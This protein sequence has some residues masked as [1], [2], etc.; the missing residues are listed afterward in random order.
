MKT[1]LCFFKRADERFDGEY[2]KKITDLFFDGGIDV[3]TLEVLSFNDISE[4]RKSFYKY[5]STANNLI[6]VGGEEADFD[7]KQIIAE[8]MN[9]TLTENENAYRFIQAVANNTGEY[10]DIENAKLPI[11]AILVPNLNGMVQGFMLEDSI[12]TLVV[13]PK[14]YTEIK[15]MIS[16][17]VVPYFDT[18]Y[19]VKKERF[20]FKYFGEIKVLE[21][22]L[23][24]IDDIYGEK[25]IKTV[26][27]KYG[28]SKVT[29]TF[30]GERSSNDVKRY[31]IEQIGENV[32][33]EFDTTLESRLF[34]LL[35]LKGV[36]LSVAE[37]FTG[38]R[39]VSSIIKNPGASK[40]VHEGI[41]SYSNQSKKSRLMVKEESLNSS[42]AVSFKVAYEM[43]AGL[44][45]AGA[46]TAISTTGIAGPKSDDTNKPVGLCYI[47]VGRTDGVHVHKYVFK[48][49]R[50]EI[51]ETAKNTAL[52]LA[53]KKLKGI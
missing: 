26:N 39:I 1:A 23:D 50:E 33:A 6:I 49:D 12:F 24:A 14:E 25:V 34:D 13:L 11:D 18:K 5:K 42:G 2:L 37:S 21:N 16:G 22:V 8:E 10:V 43:C 53:I 4:F 51:T 27:T 20:T 45:R 44:L 9:T 32:Y 7:V 30:N 48:G 47:G 38:G 41:V 35:T 52:F 40:Y 31:I 36:Y 29:L 15:P 3:D 17:Y 19:N 46:D 28:D